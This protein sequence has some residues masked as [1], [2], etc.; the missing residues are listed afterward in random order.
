LFSRA[1]ATI[2]SMR[3]RK[4]Q[5]LFYRG[6]S[7]RHVN[8]GSIL[9]PRDDLV[10]FDRIE[11]DATGAPSEH[12]IIFGAKSSGGVPV[13]VDDPFERGSVADVTVVRGDAIEHYNDHI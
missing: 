5:V 7:D 10:V 1:A 13:R 8:Q 4:L 2:S 11:R 12:A 3:K 9:K 6:I